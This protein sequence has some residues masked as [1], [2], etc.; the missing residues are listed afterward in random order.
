MTG[1]PTCYLLAFEQE[2]ALLEDTLSKLLD[3]VY[4]SD[5]ALVSFSNLTFTSFGVVI[6]RQWASPKMLEAS[7]GRGRGTRLDRAYE[8][9]A[10]KIWQ[11]NCALHCDTELQFCTNDTM[12]ARL[13]VERM[14]EITLVCAEKRL[15]AYGTNE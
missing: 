1:Y 10:Q 14:T 9:L 13:D 5:F 2:D 6:G 7:T 3:E 11:C 4:K 8:G 12:S 15:R